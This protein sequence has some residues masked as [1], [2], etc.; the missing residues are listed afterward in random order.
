MDWIESQLVRGGKIYHT[1]GDLLCIPPTPFKL[2]NNP[3][4]MNPS[5]IENSNIFYIH[6]IIWLQIELNKQSSFLYYLWASVN[7]WN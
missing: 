5:Q 7:H 3:F 4:L 2:S 6:C 1:R